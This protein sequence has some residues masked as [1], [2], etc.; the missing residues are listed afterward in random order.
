MQHEICPLDRV[1]GH[2]NSMANQQMM[3][4]RSLEIE[5]LV[6]EPLGLLASVLASSLQSTDQS[7]NHR[8]TWAGLF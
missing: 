1:E 7:E 2:C 4:S 3:S 5:S 8:H 6:V